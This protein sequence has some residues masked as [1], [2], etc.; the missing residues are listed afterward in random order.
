MHSLGR[1][2]PGVGDFWANGIKVK[3]AAQTADAELKSRMLV[4]AAKF[5]STTSDDVENGTWSTTK[6]Q[7]AAR[8][9]IMKRCAKLGYPVS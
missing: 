9:Y 8:D 7:D 1:Q 3:T 5:R 2:T 6:T 4:I